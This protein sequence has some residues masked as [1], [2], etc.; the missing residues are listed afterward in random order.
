MDELLGFSLSGPTTLAPLT[1][2]TAKLFFSSADSRDR[3]GR[4]AQYGFR[5]LMGY[6]TNQ[7]AMDH[8]RGRVTRYG[9]A[10]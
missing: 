8:L 2:T 5:A 1:L 7:L 10:R 4:A 6:Y 3:F 9:K